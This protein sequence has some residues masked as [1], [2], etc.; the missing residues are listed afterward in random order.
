MRVLAAICAPVDTHTWRATSELEKM[1]KRIPARGGISFAYVT[2]IVVICLSDVMFAGSVQWNAAPASG[3]W[4]TAVN[5]DQNIVPNGATDTATFA[6]SNQTSVSIS[7]N[8]TVDGI[9]FASGG[10]AFTIAAPSFQLTLSGAGITNNSNA[11]QNFVAAIDSGGRAG[12]FIFTNNATAGNGCFTIDGAA[13]SGTAGEGGAVVFYDSSTAGSGKFTM[14]GGTVDHAFGGG[15]TFL[16]ATNAG[17][18]AFTCNGSLANAAR[19]G[20]V[21]FHGLS[22]AGTGTFLSDGS[23]VSGAEGGRITFWDSATAGAGTFTTNG[24]K[25]S[26]GAAGQ[27]IFGF[28]STAANGTFIVNGSVADAQGGWMYFS[29]NSRAGNATI[30]VNGAAVEGGEGGLVQI[31][32]TAE[33]ATLIVNGGLVSNAA[34]GVLSFGNDAT[35]ANSTITANGGIAGGQGGTVEFTGYSTGDAAVVQLSGDAKLDISFHQHGYVTTIGSLE[36]TGNVFLG[37]NNLA[38]GGDNRSTNFSGVIRD[39]G[40]L[41]SSGGS[42]TKIGNG[43]LTLT[44]ANTYTGATIV[45]G[46]ALAVNASSSSSSVTVSGGGML[47]INSSMPNASSAIVNGGDLIVNGSLGGMVTVNGGTL[48]GSGQVGTVTVNTGGSLS[49]GNGT[50][51]LEIAG[52][53]TLSKGAT[54]RIQLDGSAAATQYQQTNVTGAVNLTKALLSLTLGFTPVPGTTFTIIDHSGSSP[55]AGSFKRLRPNAKFK[56]GGHTFR[57]SYNGGDGNDVVLTTIR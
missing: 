15:V 46:G 31:G 44:T 7:E 25:V 42:L 30:T 1:S 5:W 2:A 14:N 49:P 32:S 38:V 19:G 26:G 48:S 50:G 22:S 40:K 53:L 20:Y 23:A 29:N 12:R 39:G 45:N 41:D 28:D 33:N 10:S 47:V 6:T 21:D 24:G 57:I 43:T 35:A 13:L 18:G 17:N 52:D 16:Q 34:G 4:N 37:S 36:G 54:Y 51:I 56:V 11:E 55:V 3:D 8:V 9:I 27:T